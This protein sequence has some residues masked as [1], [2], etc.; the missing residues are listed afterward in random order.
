MS[1]ASLRLAKC[2][3][4]DCIDTPMA[5]CKHCGQEYCHKHASRYDSHFCS[6]C[7]GDE[8][9]SFEEHPL[10]DDEGVEHK[11]RK[12]RLIGEGWPRELEMIQALTD[13]ELVIKIDEWERQLKLAMIKQEFWRISVSAAKYEKEERGH[14]KRRKLESR[15]EELKQGSMRV[16][17]QLFKSKPDDASAKLSKT[18]G[19]SVEKARAVL[20]LIKKQGGAK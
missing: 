1:E 12:I 15:R 9:T 7:V 16:N 5:M 6:N 17:G 8:N 2:F 4:R 13:D 10:I 11:G 19:I 20:E 3:Q 14:N 18:L